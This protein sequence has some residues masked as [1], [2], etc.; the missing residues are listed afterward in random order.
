MGEWDELSPFMQWG[1]RGWE[2]CLD[3]S[4]WMTICSSKS[5]LLICQ[6][7]LVI[8]HV[9]KNHLSSDEAI[10]YFYFDYRD[11]EVQTSG[12]C[13][14]S[15]LRQLAARKKPFHQSLIDFYE[16]F[17]DDQPQHL[18]AELSG[19]FQ[20]MCQAYKRC[21]IM[22]DAL[23]ECRIQGHRKE[24]VRLLKSLPASNTKIFITSR[25]HSHDI[26]Q[27]FDDAL[28]ITV[29]ASE[30]DIK[31]YCSRMIDESVN[32]TDLMDDSLKQQVIRSL[33]SKADGM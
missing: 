28:K 18:V 5:W 16:R 31:H 17:R 12:Y 22:I 33:A 4:S 2:I 19:A 9:C 23:D 7:T 13:L 11:S 1:T 24:I 32:A 8:D 10:A 20:V 15:L 3:V 29:K 30:A 6:R 14:A 26:K 27:Y 21:F 25:P